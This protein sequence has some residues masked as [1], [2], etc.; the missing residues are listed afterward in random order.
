MIQL[1]V[2]VP[3][4]QG[5]KDL[6]PIDIL[7]TCEFLSQRINYG[8][9][10]LVLPAMPCAGGPHIKDDGFPTEHKR[11]LTTQKY[12]HCLNQLK[13]PREHP[14]TASMSAHTIWRQ[15]CQSWHSCC[16]ARH[17]CTLSVYIE[18]ITHQ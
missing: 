10:L 18:L 14:S 6:K 17:E 4:E 11:F 1:C 16:K 2:V 8:F 7:V 12:M 3:A 15:P 5:E 13:S 9:L